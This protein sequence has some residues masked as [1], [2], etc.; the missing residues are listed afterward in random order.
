MKNFFGFTRTTWIVVLIYLA[1]A[2]I[3]LKPFSFNSFSLIDDGQ[4][5]FLN[6]VN[7]SNCLSGSSCSDLLGQ[8]IETDFG[9]FRPMKWLIN[10]SIFLIFGNNP[11]YLHAFHILFI[12]AVIVALFSKILSYLGIRPTYQILAT[13][14]LVTR[15]SFTENI[16]RLGTDEPYYLI[17]LGIFSIYFLKRIYDPKLSSESPLRGTI[18]L[19]L[20]LITREAS[21]AI[22]PAVLFVEKYAKGKISLANIFRLLVP[23]GVLFTGIWFAKSGSD[24][25]TYSSNYIFSS[26]IMTANLVGYLKFIFSN[27][28]LFVIAILVTPILLSFEQSKRLKNAISFYIM[29]FIFSLLVYLPWRYVLDRYMLL[30]LFSL[31]I[32]VAYVLNKFHDYI[33]SHT[34]DHSRLTI[35][36]IYLFSVINIFS[37][38]FVFDYTRSVNYVKWYEEFI[39]F[40]AEQVS[41]ISQ[42]P[43]DSCVIVNAKDNLSNWEVL[44]ELPIHLAHVKNKQQTVLYSERGIDCA[45]SNIFFFSRS[46]MDLQYGTENLSSLKLMSEQ[47]YSMI[48]YNPT[49]VRDD[50]LVKPLSTILRPPRSPELSYTWQIFAVTPRELNNL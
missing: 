20:A 37:I 43:S 16:I 40:E 2:L 13:L 48:Q 31:S 29:L 18:F 33:I 28:P 47:S 1:Y 12:G 14:L 42:L 5:F 30:M 34:S 50:I 21:I 8:F 23:L 38:S 46:G 36:A 41:A 22:I 3:V 45:S 32:L 9:R 49:Q 6:H 25:V 26:D 7:F 35:L 17:F 24:Q 11:T 44:F 15:L 39:K 19:L 4:I 10:E 27:N